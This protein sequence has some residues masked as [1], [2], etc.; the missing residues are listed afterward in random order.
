MNE[1]KIRL[2]VCASRSDWISVSQ[3]LRGETVQQ[4][5]ASR[6]QT[7]ITTAQDELS[8]SKN[9]FR[10][11]KIKKRPIFFCS[12][13]RKHWRNTTIHYTFCVHTHTDTHN[14]KKTRLCFRSCPLWQPPRCPCP[15]V[16]VALAEKLS[17]PDYVPIEFLLCIWSYCLN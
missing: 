17:I 9:H 11:V 12:C 5:K 15:L 4:K 6:R 16:A 2:N 1:A 10:F 8:T 7:D 14:R 3:K 13:F